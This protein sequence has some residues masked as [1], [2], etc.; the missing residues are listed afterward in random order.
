MIHHSKILMS[1]PNAF[2]ALG[3][4]IFGIKHDRSCLR[5]F[6]DLSHYVLGINAFSKRW[7]AKASWSW[8]GKNESY[9][10]V[11]FVEIDRSTSQVF[12]LNGKGISPTCHINFCPC[13]H[14]LYERV[15]LFVSRYYY[16][17]ER[18]QTIDD[19]W[20]RFTDLLDVSAISIC[21]GNPSIFIVFL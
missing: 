12:V 14:V 2:I 1:R 9:Y 15:I 16:G 11:C 13:L 10:W 3:L 20:T 21:E 6:S 7:S 8:Y 17:I 19:R 4:R 5:I 18:Q